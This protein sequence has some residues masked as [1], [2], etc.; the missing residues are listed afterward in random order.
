RIRAVGSDWV[1]LELVGDS[2]DDSAVAA[3]A[4][5]IRTGAHLVPAFDHPETVAG[6]GSVIREAVGQLGHAPDL[7]VVPV[8]GGGLLAGTLSWLAGHHPE[9]RVVGV[10][11]A[12]AACMA[13]ALT[14]GRPVELSTLNGFVDGAAVRKAGELTY[15]IVRD[16]GAELVS[17]PEGRVC[18]EML[19]FYQAD[20]II[21]EPAGALAAAALGETVLAEPGQT[22]LCLLSGGNN[23]ASRYAEVIERA[24]VHEGRKHYFLVDLRQE[25]GALRGFLDEV[26]G[27]EDDITLFEYVK[28]SS[29]ETGP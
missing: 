12:G 29:R 18:S 24:L 27:P 15:Q 8:G 21:A 1:R 26:L 16:G 14:A 4:Y 20:G 13:A 17:V 9:V 23:D 11:P 19:A 28:R 10:E 6:Q 2:Y 22:T 7:V 3:Q 25:P 5:S